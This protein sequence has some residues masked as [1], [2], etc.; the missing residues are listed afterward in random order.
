[1]GGLCTRIVRLGFREGEPPDERDRKKLLMPMC[2]VAGFIGAFLLL[3][4]M[5]RVSIEWEETDE[6][7]AKK[8]GRLCFYTEYFILTLA[9][10]GVFFLVV[11]T[12]SLSKRACELF[13]LAC[14][15]AILLFDVGCLVYE[16]PPSLSLVVL[17]LD[18]LLLVDGRA[19]AATAVIR[20]TV[21]WATFRSVV[22]VEQL[23]D[24]G[25][26]ETFEAKWWTR[27]ITIFTL[28][29]IVTIIDFAATRGFATN[30]RHQQS[31]ITAAVNC[32]EMATVHLSKYNIEEARAVLA[33]AEGDLL[34]AALRNA[35]NQLVMNLAAYRPYLPQ[36]CL[37]EDNTE[38]G[39]V[40]ENIDVDE[41]AQI[42]GLVVSGLPVQ[43][44]ETNSGLE[45]AVHSEDGTVSVLSEES[46]AR[47]SLSRRE[48]DAP[49]HRIESSV[50]LIAA[51]P[52]TK[53]ITLL[54]ANRKG[55][56]TGVEEHGAGWLRSTIA[57]GVDAFGAAVAEH[58]GV[59]DL[60]SGDHNFASFGGAR[61]CMSPRL[62]AV[63]ATGVL[64]SSAAEGS[65]CVCSGF[66]VAGDF[67][68]QDQRRYMT[69]GVLHSFL[70]VFERLAAAAEETPLV[71]KQ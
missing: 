29:V 16:Y 13:I 50:G 67:G 21:V 20:V 27:V 64:R 46:R 6:D 22:S 69:V 23:K 1:M 10:L 36:S 44:V 17:V 14:A 63:R 62:S 53:R 56:L 32:S 70:L 12:K 19:S 7:L 34:P 33:S 18:A 54:A 26:Y 35:L 8:M 38:E 42:S 3:T 15:V 49:P 31:M 47:T 59:V 2:L 58:R 30:M 57:E 11:R 66:A 52:K 41:S 61:T 55:F 45:D 51:V 25:N 37:A 48:S 71:D 5:S 24:V 28:N 43:H 65:L 40:E 39:S 9:G 60:I 4:S 68:G